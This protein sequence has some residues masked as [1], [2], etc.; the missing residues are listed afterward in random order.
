M[1]NLYSRRSFRKPEKEDGRQEE[2]EEEEEE[3]EEAGDAK[4]KTLEVHGAF[5]D[6][7][8]W[9]FVEVG[10]SNGENSEPFLPR[11]TSVVS[12]SLSPTPPLS[13]TSSPTSSPSRSE[14]TSWSSQWSTSSQK[15]TAPARPFL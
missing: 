9:K 8:F 14:T 3:V 2:E 6:E 11:L 4:E 15:S 5:S 7:Y 13:Q 1:A 12:P 10:D